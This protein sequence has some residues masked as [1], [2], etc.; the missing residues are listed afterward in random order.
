MRKPSNDQTP[1]D[2][3]R[4][5][6]L[7]A[8]LFVLATGGTFEELAEVVAERMGRPITA[9]HIIQWLKGNRTASARVRKALAE[10]LG[11]HGVA[12]VTGETDRV[13]MGPTEEK[14]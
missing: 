10:V 2:G 1:F 7:R 9:H 5:N 11:D 8:R 3:R 14:R 13:P 4:P 6:Y 12:F